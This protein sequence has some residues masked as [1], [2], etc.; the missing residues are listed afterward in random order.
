M[1][2]SFERR[3]QLEHVVELGTLL[4]E[5]RQVILDLKE[6]TLVCFDAVRF[7]GLCELRGIQL[8]NSPA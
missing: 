4:R 3:I 2:F 8:R 1:T 6:V 5:H 7:L